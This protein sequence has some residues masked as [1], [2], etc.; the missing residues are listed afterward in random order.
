MKLKCSEFST[1]GNREIKMRRKNSVL[2]YITSHL[3]RAA[4]NLVH[5]ELLAM[6]ELGIDKCLCFQL[7]VT[8]PYVLPSRK[9]N[10]THD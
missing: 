3:I 7:N 2:Q 6:L 1:W 9:F 5:Y 8:R 4:L 10:V